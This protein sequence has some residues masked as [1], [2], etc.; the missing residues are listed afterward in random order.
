MW[1]RRLFSRIPSSASPLWKQAASN[2][3]LV[4][5]ECPSRHPLFQPDVVLLHLNILLPALDSIGCED[6]GL[7]GG[8]LTSCR[9]LPCRYI[10]A[11]L[12]VVLACALYLCYHFDVD[13]VNEGHTNDTSF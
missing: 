12:Q 4:I 13:N 8:R 9:S 7:E 6:R 10:Q 2:P 1:T 3:S 5:F 11:A